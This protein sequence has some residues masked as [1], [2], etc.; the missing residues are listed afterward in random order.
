MV[1]QVSASSDLLTKDVG[2]NT[3]R[4]SPQGANPGFIEMALPGAQVCGLIWG[5]FGEKSKKTI[6][7]E[8]GNFDV[9]RHLFK[10]NTGICP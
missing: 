3:W 5:K 10:P 7:Y 6:G 9:C 2:F 4:T 8:V 1:C